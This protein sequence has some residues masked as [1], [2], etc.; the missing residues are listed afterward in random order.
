MKKFK[1]CFCN[2]E[3]IKQNF[4]ERHLEEKHEEQLDGLSGAQFYFNFKNKYNKKFGSCIICKGP[5][6][7]NE[8]TKKYNRLC[9]NPQC[10]DKYVKMFRARMMKIYGKENLLKDAEQQEKMLANRKISSQYEWHDGK[11]FIYTGTYELEFL[12]M[13]D[14]ILNWNSSDLIAPAPMTFKY[15]FEKEDHF[16]I[17]DFYI[18]S[19]N[20]IIEVKG[21]N[22][23]YQKR[24]LDKELLKEKAVLDTKKYNYI[25][26]KDKNY[27]PF[28]EGLIINKWK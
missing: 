5:T 23:H 16:Y 26:I 11:K 9:E 20:L 27:D 17:P 21:S 6:K 22:N 28:L 15:K 25:K 2:C 19:I 10:K 3:F 8:S 1:C 12:K 13:M 4:L 24:D 18:P 7:F 14:L